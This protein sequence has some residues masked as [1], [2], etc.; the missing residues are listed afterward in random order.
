MTRRDI[1][2]HLFCYFF[3]KV[4]FEKKNPKNKLTH[5][6]QQKC[7]TDTLNLTYVQKMTPYLR[8]DKICH[9]LSILQFFNSVI[10]PTVL[11]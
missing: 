9:A 7:R 2:D 6:A 11:Q 3:L 8:G 1:F 4:E 5:R 10:D